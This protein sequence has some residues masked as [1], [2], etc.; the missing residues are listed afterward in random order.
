MTKLDKIKYQI[1]MLPMLLSA[2]IDAAAATATVDDVI[3]TDVTTAA[4]TQFVYPGD[5]CCSLLTAVA[6]TIPC[7]PPPPVDN[8]RAVMIVWRGRLKMHESKMRYGQNCRGGKCK[9][10]K[11][12]SKWQG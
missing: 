7:V 6:Y 5:R 2:D 10:G 12:G 8:T 11:C 4:S 9:N 1:H 3:G